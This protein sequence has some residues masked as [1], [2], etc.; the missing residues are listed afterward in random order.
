MNSARVTPSMPFSLDDGRA[1]FILKPGAVGSARRIS[2]GEALRIDDRAG[3]TILRD[4][5]PL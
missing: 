2:D 5:T 4:S 1:G 3:V